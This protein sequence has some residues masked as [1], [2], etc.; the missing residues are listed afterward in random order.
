MATLLKK[1]IGMAV[2]VILSIPY[3]AALFLS[4]ASVMPQGFTILL[5]RH[6]SVSQ[7]AG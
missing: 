6:S 3:A 4:M 7:Q 1:P 5:P 2:I